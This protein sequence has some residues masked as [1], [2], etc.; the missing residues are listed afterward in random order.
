MKVWTHNKFTGHYP[1][2]AA[3]VVCGTTRED[4]AAQ[5]EEALAQ[6]GLKQRIEPQDLVEF[7]VFGSHVRVLNDGNY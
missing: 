5:L 1:V 6:I 7:E 4:A 3:A 2:G